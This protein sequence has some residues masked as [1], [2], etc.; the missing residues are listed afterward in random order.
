MKFQK[1]PIVIDAEQFDCG[2]PV[3]E[4]VC[5]LDH[6]GMMDAHVHTLEGPLKVS[7][8]DWIITG[9]K[10]EKYPCKPDIF[11]QIYSRHDEKPKDVPAFPQ[12]IDDMGTMRSLN[13][14]LTKL[15]YFAGCALKGMIANPGTAGSPSD[16]AKY[17]FRYADAMVA[18][19]E[20]EI[21]KK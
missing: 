21:D 14:G 20:S 3:P 2:R 7:N 5:I 12:T 16:I 1:K 8:L 18:F 11:E 4:G 17:A 15:E 6:D 19:S 10:G 9:V 13:S